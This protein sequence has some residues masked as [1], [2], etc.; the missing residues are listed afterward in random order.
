[1]FFKK[2]KANQLYL[3]YELKNLLWNREESAS[4]KLQITSCLKKN[5]REIKAKED[6]EHFLLE[7]LSNEL[8]YWF[9]V[10]EDKFQEILNSVDLSTGT[11]AV[12]E[13]DK[14]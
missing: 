6:A 3:K 11:S 2:D 7:E 12:P 9:D 4:R 1:M 14:V 13:K 10:Y 5:T 8:E